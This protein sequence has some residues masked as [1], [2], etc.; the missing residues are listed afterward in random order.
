MKGQVAAEA[1]AAL[2]LAEEG[3]R[4]EAG[5]LLLVFTGDEETG[6]EYGA[7]L[8]VRAAPRAVRCDM[9]VNEGAGAVIEFDG[10]RRLRRVRGREGRLPLHAHHLGPRRPRLDPADRRTTRW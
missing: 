7:A 5:E 1:A 10:R 6:A 8:A 2:A 3:W 9:V 4:P